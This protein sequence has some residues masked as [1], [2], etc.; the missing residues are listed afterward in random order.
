LV[1]LYLDGACVKERLRLQLLSILIANSSSLYKSSDVVFLISQRFVLESKS[2][3]IYFS[4]LVERNISNKLFTT[5]T[6]FLAA[7]TFNL[8]I[9]ESFHLSIKIKNSCFFRATSL[10]PSSCSRDEILERRN[11]RVNR[12]NNRFAQLRKFNLQVKH[13]LKVLRFAIINF[14]QDHIGWRT[15]FSIF[16]LHV[17]EPVRIRV[18]YKT[19]ILV[20]TEVQFDTGADSYNEEQ[21]GHN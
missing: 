21:S 1:K 12:G 11:P 14:F 9:Y 13:D 17:E 19:N 3:S 7:I 16:E 18:F 5:N 4:I 2:S 6:E 10:I 8:D 20:E 15:S